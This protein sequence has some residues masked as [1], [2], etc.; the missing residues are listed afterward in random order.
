MSTYDS[1]NSS[2]GSAEQNKNENAE[3][4]SGYRGSNPSTAGPG[5]THV[6]SNTPEGKEGEI[7]PSAPE[8]SNTT[9]LPV[10]ED[11]AEIK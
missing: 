2:P 6:T 1:K 7:N 9:P 3:E 8:A 5:P 4:P 11:Q 10:P